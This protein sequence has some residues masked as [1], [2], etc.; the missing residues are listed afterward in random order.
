MS[1]K[2]ALFPGPRHASNGFSVVELMVVISIISIITAIAAPS[3]ALLTEI[4]RVREVV[5]QLQSTLYYARSEAIRRGGQIVMQKVPDSA[6]GCKTNET[7]SWNCGWFVCYD[8][9]NDGNCGAS[10]AVLQRIGSAGKVEVSR[11]RGGANIKFN[12]WGLVSGIYIGFTLIPKNKTVSHVGARGVC[13]SSGGR[14]RV[15]PQDAIPCV[16]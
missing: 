7:N 14:I 15:V 2:K 11:N 1:N 6:D 13:M 5:D 10:E 9:N 3:F 16:G 4:W 8:S 12:R